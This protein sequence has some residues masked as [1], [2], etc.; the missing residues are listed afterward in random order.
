VRKQPPKGLLERQHPT[1]VPAVEV[2][3][4]GNS[5]RPTY[6]DHQDVLGEVLAKRLKR[7]EEKRKLNRTVRPIQQG[8]KRKRNVHSLAFLHIPSHSL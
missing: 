3:A 4:P 1:N 6:D 2:A 7:K 5:Y 8:L